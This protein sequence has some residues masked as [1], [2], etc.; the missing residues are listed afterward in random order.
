[1]RRKLSV[2]LTA[3]ISLFCLGAVFAQNQQNDELEFSVDLSG[4]SIALPKL[5]KTNID[6]SGRGVSPDV[7][8]PQ[9][10][11]DQKTLQAWKDEIGFNAMYRLQYSLWDINQLAKDKEK[12]DKLLENYGS[13]IKEVNGQGGIVL[14]NIFSTPAGLGKV[15]DKKSFPWDLN[16]FK[17]LIKGYIRELSCNKKYNIWYE[18]WSAPDL[19]LFFLGRTPEYLNLYKAIAEAVKELEVESGIHIPVGGPSSSWWFQNCGG[20][21]IVTPENSLIYELIK[22]CSQNKLPLDFISWHA[23]STDPLAEKERTPYNHTA[24]YLIR[25]WLSYFNL[26][27]NTPLV[28][29]EWNYDSGANILPERK[30]NSYITASYILSRMKNMNEAGID[31]QLFFSLEDFYNKQEGI[32]RNV[33]VF[34]FDEE[35]PESGIIP[36]SIYNTFKMLAKLGDTMYIPAEKNGSE[37][38]GVIFTKKQDDYII[39]IYNYIDPD[40]QKNYLSRN[41]C[42]LNELERQSLIDIVQ[43][44]GLTKLINK[45]IDI[46]GLQMDPK[47]KTMLNTALELHNYSTK[48]ISNSRDIKLVIRNLKD[49]YLYQRYIMGSSCSLGCELPLVEEK[50]IIS[51]ELYEEKLSLSPYSVTMISLKKKPA[52]VLAQ[53]LPLANQTETKNITIPESIP[54]NPAIEVKNNTVVLNATTVMVNNTASNVTNVTQ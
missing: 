15:L 26:D 47:V 48:F 2:V 43:S 4:P 53:P 27:K 1:M 38:V 34:L 46:A 44:D 20:N 9:N 52:E 12:Q 14:L 32:I 51:P 35:K 5:F 36:K 13:V 25:E 24:A 29:D 8:W 37:F 33:G 18:V 11:A 17:E 41:I 19:D 28:I 50:T 42:S 6:L 30:E 31:H 23:Y 40:L 54:A 45:E 49:Q 10:L 39:L 16:A 22:F 7:S 3:A 21:T